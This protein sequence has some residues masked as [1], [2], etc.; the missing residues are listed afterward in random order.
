MPAVSRFPPFDLNEALLIAKTIWDHGAGQPMR[1][2]TI[3]NTLRRSPE[4]SMSRQLVTASSGFGLTSGGPN[5]ET[6]SLLDR[7]RA[8]VELDD[9][10]A[11]IDA[12][13]GVPIFG[14]FFENYRNVTVPSPSAAIDFLKSQGLNEGGAKACL[15]VLISTGEQ[16][17]L[18]QDMS[19]VKRV[20]SADHALETLSKGA[21]A[22]PPNPATSDG[23]L[24]RVASQAPTPALEAPS[25]HIDI[26]IHIAADAKPEQIEQVFA[27]MEKHIYR[28]E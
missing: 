24:P 11:R 23:R 28:R 5:A 19:G 20:V 13:L 21:P 2:L 8:I 25:V 17:A 3:F 15:D 10:Q 12:V 16:V 7:G 18:I 6:I 26:Q 9:P 4:S 14:K 27:S 22:R 1:R